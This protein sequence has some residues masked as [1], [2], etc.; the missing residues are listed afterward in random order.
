MP[1]AEWVHHADDEVREESANVLFAAELAWLCE[2]ATDAGAALERAHTETD[3]LRGLLWEMAFSYELAMNEM[4]AGRTCY[5]QL[6]GNS[7]MTLC[8]V[9]D[10]VHQSFD[11]G[12]WSTD[13]ADWSECVWFSGHITSC[14]PCGK[15]E[16]FCIG[17]H[18]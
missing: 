1:G 5:S 3:R 15:L 14:A 12:C 2:Y 6:P 18:E 8:R 16:P 9:V 17:D 13:Y 7:L 10:G 4:R 11:F